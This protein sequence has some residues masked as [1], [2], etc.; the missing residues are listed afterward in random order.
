MSTGY[1]LYEITV[2]VDYVPKFLSILTDIKN[3]KVNGAYNRISAIT[4]RDLHFI[5]QIVLFDDEYLLIKLSIPIESNCL[6]R[7]R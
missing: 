3:T 1:A 5:Y 6:V 2:V 4:P 7:Y